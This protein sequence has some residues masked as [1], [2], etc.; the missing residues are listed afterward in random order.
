M[1]PTVPPTKPLRIVSDSSLPSTGHAHSRSVSVSFSPLSSPGTPSTPNDP[2]AIPIRWTKDLEQRL[3]L[4]QM[5]LEEHQRRWSAGQE[6]YLHEVEALQEL[7]RRF[8]KFIRRRSKQHSKEGKRFL[9]A[10]SFGSS[11]V[12]EMADEDPDQDDKEQAVKKRPGSLLRRL[13]AGMAQRRNS[14]QSALTATLSRT[15]SYG[16]GRSLGTF[17]LRGGFSKD[18]RRPQTPI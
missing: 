9:R 5:S 3:R 10:A 2:S 13:S 16:S 14:D 17:L 18:S 12:E 4:A 15:S 7:K 1:A 11:D 6:E 8:E